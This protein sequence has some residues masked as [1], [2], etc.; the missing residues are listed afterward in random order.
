MCYVDQF[1]KGANQFNQLFQCN[2]GE[3]TKKPLMIPFELHCEEG[4]HI[5]VGKDRGGITR[6]LLT[7]K[8]LTNPQDISEET[9][10]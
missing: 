3:D 10:Y 9:L 2:S 5:F 4:I 6:A 7:S 8:N 1:L